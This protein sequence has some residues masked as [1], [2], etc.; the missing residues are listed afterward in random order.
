MTLVSAFSTYFASQEPSTAA[1]NSSF[2]TEFVLDGVT[3]VFAITNLVVTGRNTLC[4]ARS[5]IVAEF[6]RG[7][8]P[9]HRDGIH[10][11]KIQLL[12]LI[13]KYLDQERP[14][15]LRR[16]GSWHTLPCLLLSSV[17]L[18]LV[19]E[20]DTTI[21]TIFSSSLLSCRLKT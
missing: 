20:L 8:D 2:A 18:D 12:I 14:D 6:L 19:V 16:K 10:D 7:R 15:V 13:K 1:S 3:F 5:K 11:G 17:P 9:Y 4:T 21:S